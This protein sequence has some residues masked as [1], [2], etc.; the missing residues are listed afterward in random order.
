MR[1][2]P[3]LSVGVDIVDV[4]RMTRA[5][6]RPGFAARCFT[7]AERRYCAARRLPGQHYAARF[8]AKEALC[9]AV[10][11][12]LAWQ[13]IELRRSEMGAPAVRVSGAAG[14]L[15]E[16]ACVSVS[17]SHCDCHAAAVALVAREAA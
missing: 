5:L 16:G 2:G 1:A 12:R 10:G 4:A 15:L 9:K 11:R 7:A 6:R 8:A 14:R 17:L 3:A 13:E